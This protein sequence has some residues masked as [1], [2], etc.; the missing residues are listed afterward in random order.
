MVDYLDIKLKADYVRNDIFV[1]NKD[2]HLVDVDEM[3]VENDLDNELIYVG[4]Y[5]DII[6]Y[7]LEEVEKEHI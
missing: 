6:D 5:V 3:E 4:N 7:L 2:Y 1:G